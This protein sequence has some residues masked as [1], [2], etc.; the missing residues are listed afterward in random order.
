MTGAKPRRVIATALLGFVALKALPTLSEP[1]IT[2]T[3]SVI[4]GDT[5]EIHGQRIR[6][7]GIDAPES[8]QL[9]E[10]P[11][12]SRYRCGQV[13]AFALA[14]T[15]GRKPVSCNGQDRDRYDRIIAVC[16]LSGEDLNGWMVRQGHAV[17][18]RRYSLDYVSA[19][20]A[21]EHDGLGIWSGRFVL[22]WL[23]RRGERL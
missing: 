17:A 13:A 2:G 11:D 14:N 21:A 20:E 1:T 6:L 12:G 4:D 10:G 9:C 23:W 3:A 18:Y 19:E 22:P 8:S 15:I 5:I 7:H 16:F